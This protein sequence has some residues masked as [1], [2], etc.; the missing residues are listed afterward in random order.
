MMKQKQRTLAGTLQGLSVQ[1][2]VLTMMN[3]APKEYF[4]MA[5]LLPVI[6]RGKSGVCACKAAMVAKGLVELMPPEM[7]EHVYDDARLSPICITELG[8][9]WL[10]EQEGDTVG[11]EL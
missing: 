5:E 7:I 10:M 4:I 1:Q 3:S 11:L 6:K 8:I 2:Q 9:A